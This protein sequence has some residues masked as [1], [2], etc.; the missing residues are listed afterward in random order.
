MV[1]V[2]NDPISGPQLWFG[3]NPNTVGMYQPVVCQSEPTT[4]ENRAL[5]F[6][7]IIQHN[8]ADEGTA[9]TAVTGDVT[10]HEEA[11]RVHIDVLVGQLTVGGLSIANGGST[12]NNGSHEFRVIEAGSSQGAGS[13]YAARIQ[14]TV[15]AGVITAITAVNEPGHS[16]TKG[17]TLSCEATGGGGAGD[18]TFTVNVNGVD[19][20]A[21]GQ[22]AYAN[23]V[24]TE[25]NSRSVDLRNM[26]LLALNMEYNT[27]SAFNTNVTADTLNDGDITFDL[28]SIANAASTYNNISVGGMVLDDKIVGSD[29]EYLS[30]D[31]SGFAQAASTIA[32]SL[33]LTVQRNRSFRL[34]LD[35]K[36]YALRDLKPIPVGNLDFDNITNLQSYG[37]PEALWVA[38]E[39][40][41]GEIRNNLYMPLPQRELRIARHPNNGAGIEVS[42]VYLLFTWRGRLQR[43]F[44]QNL[45]DLGPDFPFE[46][47]EL[48]GD[49]VDIITYPGRVYVAVDGG[50]QG[51]SMVLCHKGGGWHE[52]Y[53]GFSGERIRGLYIQSIP[54]KSDKLW[55]GSGS[56]LMYTHI[57]LDPAELPSNNDYKF[58]GTGYLTSSWVYTAHSELNKLFR[59]MVVTM[60]RANDSNLK[61]TVQYQLDDEDNDWQ[62]TTK[63]T[64]IS[65][66]AKEFFFGDLNKGQAKSGNRIRVRL[67][68]ETLDASKS[69]VVRS[70]QHKMYR[71]PEVKFA[72][73]FLSKI[74]SLSIN[75][76]G[77]EE[78]VLG[79][80]AS[81]VE[82]LAIMDNWAQTVMPLTVI[83]NVAMLH[84]KLV[85]LEPLPTQLLMIVSDEDLEEE[86]IQVALNDA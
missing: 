83:S 10:V 38:T 64:L 55:W 77:D 11:G 78:K 59:S 79:T 81:L 68:L 5:N 25:G 34:T 73:T 20:F 22:I 31:N 29:H 15:T 9:W 74:S 85:I 2:L 12:Y 30:M 13:A 47:G 40:G 42:D 67:V 35:G 51:R 53:T 14:C 49:I 24:D 1:Q 7:S 71:L 27:G 82:A 26:N 86:S 18:G 4:W 23:I 50:D 3:E 75:L 69:P 70:L 21:T 84:E 66:S 76:R 43:Y 52:V 37:D 63:D 41:L 8:G 57:A 48:E 62:T 56:D 80:Q 45:E 17:A 19:G 36:T 61:V 72:Y 44:R 58:R 28:S 6:Q 33:T 54:G 39:T 16:Y 60:Q 32:V 65:A 46:L